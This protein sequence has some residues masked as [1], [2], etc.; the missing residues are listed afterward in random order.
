MDITHRR[1]VQNLKADP[2]VSTGFGTAFTQSGSGR[3]YQ[4]RASAGFERRFL[5]K[6]VA[7]F[8][9]RGQRDFGED[10]SDYGAEITLD[11]QVRLR[12][13]GRF[14]SKVESFFGFSD[15]K[16]IS[17]ENYNTL[18]FPLLGELSL[19]VRQ[20]NFMYRLDKIRG[21]PVSGIAFRSDL[22]I[23]LTYGIDWKWL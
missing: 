20:N 4:V 22:T 2:F 17:I 7:Q 14:R 5:S 10:Q 16:V 9:A 8:A 12:Q 11:Y 21:V 3:P 19:S 6:W 13:G 1:R 15:R 23:G 18:N